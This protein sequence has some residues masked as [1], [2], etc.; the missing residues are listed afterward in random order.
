MRNVAAEIFLLEF[1]LLPGKTMIDVNHNKLDAPLINLVEANGTS[2]LP[3]GVRAALAIDNHVRR[4][5]RDEA[6]V[7][8]V[9][10]DEGA[11]LAVASV[12][13]FGIQSQVLAR[14]RR[15]C[16]RGQGEHR[17]EESD[18]DMLPWGIRTV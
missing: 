2:R 3:L 10:R 16:Q 9:A 4:L 14:E 12:V 18:H 7:H 6:G 13:E 1:L 5:A 17:D 15:R 11:I 8:A